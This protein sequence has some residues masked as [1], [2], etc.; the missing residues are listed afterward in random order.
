MMRETLLLAATESASRTPLLVLL[1]YMGLLLGLGVMS[2]RLFR[3]TSK[4]YFVASES[5]GPFMLLMSVSVC[6]RYSR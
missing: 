6:L 1:V 4:D 5:I 3:G 2:G